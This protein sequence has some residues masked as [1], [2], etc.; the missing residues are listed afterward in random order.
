MFLNRNTTI[1][2]YR[3]TTVFDNNYTNPI[4]IDV[5]TYEEW[6]EGHISCAVGPLAI[7]EK[8]QENLKEK[9]NEIIGSYKNRTIFVYCRSGRRSEKAKKIL[10]KLG[11]KDV[12]NG[13]GYKICS[14]E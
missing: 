5:R 6:K 10:E 9:L 1:C 11:Y 14:Y 2:C 8:Q 3:T 7:H 4:I 13:G 12:R